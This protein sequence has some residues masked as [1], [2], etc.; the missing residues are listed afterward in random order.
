MIWVEEVK[1]WE[2][3]FRRGPFHVH[4]KNRIG[5]NG[6]RKNPFKVIFGD[7]PEEQMLR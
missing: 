7:V 2:A 3:D 5:P 4:N 1:D 6:E